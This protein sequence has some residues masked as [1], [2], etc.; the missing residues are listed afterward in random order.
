MFY[1]VLFELKLPILTQG[2]A[3]PCKEVAIRARLLD[4]ELPAGIAIV[5]TMDGTKHAIPARDIYKLPPGV[6]T[7]R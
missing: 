2:E 4:I 6:T 1:A 5:R 7:V 3:P